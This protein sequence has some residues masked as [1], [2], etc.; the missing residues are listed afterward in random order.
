MFPSGGAKVEDIDAEELKIGL[1][2][3]DSY[4]RFLAE[5]ERIKPRCYKIM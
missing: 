2:L 1:A 4:R 5:M 3:S